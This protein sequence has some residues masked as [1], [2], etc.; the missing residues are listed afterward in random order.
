MKFKEFEYLVKLSVNGLICSK[1]KLDIKS[2]IVVVL[3]P[4]N[5]VKINPAINNIKGINICNKKTPIEPNQ[6]F[7]TNFTPDL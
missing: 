1:K 4:N 3:V 2:I 7:K 6:D 5:F